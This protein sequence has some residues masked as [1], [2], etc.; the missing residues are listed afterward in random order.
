MASVGIIANP[1]AGKDIRRIV[2]Q[3]RFVPNNEK[4]N[5]LKRVLS[6]LDAVGVESV[7][8][9]PDSGML[10][11]GA[12]EGSK[13]NVEPEFI[14]MPIFHAEEDSTRAAAHMRERGVGCIITLGGDGTNR[15]VAKETGDVPI[16][17]ISTGTNNVFPSM[18]EGT[19]AGMAAGLI[20]LGVV[21][22]DVATVRSNKLELNLDGAVKDIALVD[23][24]VSYERFVGA[25]AIWNMDTLHE[26]FLCR[27]EPSSIGLSAIGAQLKP[28]SLG[29]SGGVRITFGDGNGSVI[30]PVAPGMI[31]PVKIKAW[32]ALEAGDTTEVTLRPST[33][34]L[35]GERTLSLKPRDH[36]TVTLSEDGPLVVDVNNTLRAASEIGYL[37]SSGALLESNSPD[38]KDS[39]AI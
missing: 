38:G 24:A 36:A 16:L 7:L 23:L 35:D 11:R 5:I 12:M 28:I 8:F 15:A 20:S 25:R 39:N 17:P 13:F 4:V 31:L 33:I 26:V 19:V 34:A 22:I 1:A 27:A 29:E 14:D 10:G 21:P 2:A 18:I 3:G 37:R 32:Q 6:G 30:A 9:M